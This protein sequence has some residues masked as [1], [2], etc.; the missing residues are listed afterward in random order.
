VGEVTPQDTRLRAISSA[1][2]E[3]AAYAAYGRD[4]QLL[5]YARALN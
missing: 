1:E 4:Y 5:G 3:G 2:V